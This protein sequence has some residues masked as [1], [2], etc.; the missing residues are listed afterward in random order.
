MHEVAEYL[1][2]NRI[3]FAGVDMIGDYITEINI[4]SPTGI[5]QIEEKD[6]NLSLEI[7]S[8]FISIVENYY[9]RKR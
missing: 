6:K 3:Y 5:R 2:Y 4:T 9:D 7:A 8:Q 1:K